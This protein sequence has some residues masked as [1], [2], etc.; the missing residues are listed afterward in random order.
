MH[1]RSF[2]RRGLLSRIVVR[3][4]ITNHVDHDNA[5][6]AVRAHQYTSSPVIIRWDLDTDDV[7]TTRA[8]HLLALA[9]ARLAI[10]RRV[11]RRAEPS[12]AFPEDLRRK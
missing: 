12:S 9:L 10:R 2:T 7:V 8:Q 5:P 6:I 1:R 4:V 11:R 3:D